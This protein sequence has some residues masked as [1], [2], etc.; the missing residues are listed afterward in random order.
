VRK[1][2]VQEITA[3]QDYGKPLLSRSH[4]RQLLLGIHLGFSYSKKRWLGGTRLI[5]CTNANVQAVIGDA[6]SRPGGRGL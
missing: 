6:G 2:V 3:G 4:S 1:V 5:C